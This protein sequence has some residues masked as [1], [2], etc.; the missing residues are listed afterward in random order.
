MSAYI[1]I[2]NCSFLAERQELKGQSGNLSDKVS[3]LIKEES[4]RIPPM[5]SAFLE[6]TME[7]YNDEITDALPSGSASR[8]LWEQQKVALKKGKQMRWHPAIIR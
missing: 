1:L 3:A 5:T 7:D 4:A 2:H 8:L 6:K